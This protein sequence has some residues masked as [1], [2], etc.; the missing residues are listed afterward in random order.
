LTTI[1]ARHTGEGIFFSS[2]MFDTFDI[3]SGGISF[4]H[5]DG[6]VNDWIRD[7]PQYQTA[8]P[9]GLRFETRRAVLRKKCSMSMSR[10]K[11]TTSAALSCRYASHSTSAIP[12]SRSQAKRVLAR[13]DLFRTV[14]STLADRFNWPG[15]RGQIFRVFAQSHP[16]IELHFIHANASVRK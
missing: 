7:N 4:S 10:A 6:E 11:T 8:L 1:R 5:T 2:R 13:V 9:C 3:L 15:V 12:I 16:E 14:V